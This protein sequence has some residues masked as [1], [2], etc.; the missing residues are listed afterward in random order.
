M[1]N[2]VLFALCFLAIAWSVTPEA[3]AQKPRMAFDTGST[4]WRGERIELPPGFAPDMQWKGTEDIRFAPGMFQADADDFFTYVLVFLLEKDS[5]VSLQAI[6]REILTYY[7]GLSKAVSKGKVSA[8]DA[9]KFTVE[10]NQE[11]EVTLNPPGIQKEGV[12]GYSGKLDWI[13]PFASQKPQTLHF[14]AQL[15]KHGEQPALFLCVSPQKREAKIWESL[16]KIRSTFR[17]E[18]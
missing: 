3:V 4:M 12:T 8:A 10:M 2:R 7:R 16:R 13:E 18:D 17:I 6:Q 1:W 15:W 11:S 9:G 5:D 14:E